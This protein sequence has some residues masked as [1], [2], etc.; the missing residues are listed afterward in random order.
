MMRAVLIALRKS[1]IEVG[2]TENWIKGTIDSV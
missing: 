2:S 1:F